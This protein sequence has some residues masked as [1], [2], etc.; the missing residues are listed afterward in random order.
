MKAIPV[1]SE[2]MAALEAAA[3]EEGKPLAA[4][5]DEAFAAYLD[6]LAWK[7]EVIEKIEEAEAAAD[8]PNAKFF[9]PEE[10]RAE[11]NRRKAEYFRRIE[12]AK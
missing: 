8:D 3:R 10:S 12:S 4:F 7:R 6:H 11:L 1:T 9:T 2:R 5:A